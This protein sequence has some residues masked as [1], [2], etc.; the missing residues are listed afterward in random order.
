MYVMYMHGVMIG[1]GEDG[2]G[3][4]RKGRGKGNQLIKS[5][6]LAVSLSVS[7]WME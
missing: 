2:R 7:E 6:N 5:E 1:S 3:K 4:G